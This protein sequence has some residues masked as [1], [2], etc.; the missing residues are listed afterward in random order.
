MEVVDLA[1]ALIRISYLGVDYRPV[2]QLIKSTTQPIPA[3]VSVFIKWEIQHLDTKVP[4]PVPVLQ[5]PIAV[6][7]TI[8]VCLPR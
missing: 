8:V 4:V 2:M 3:M 1:S 7:T 5:P 6:T